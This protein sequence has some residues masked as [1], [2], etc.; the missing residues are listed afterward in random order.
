M[1][2]VSNRIFPTILKETEI[3]FHECALERRCSSIYVIY[4]NI[5]KCIFIYVEV[6]FMCAGMKCLYLWSSFPGIWPIPPCYI[7]HLLDPLERDINIF[8]LPYI[9]IITY[10]ELHYNTSI[11][12]VFLLPYIFIILCKYISPWK[13]HKYI[14]IAIYFNFSV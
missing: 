12:N 4:I 3:E 9:S 5:Y 11:I 8:L 2:I 6:Y 10:I 13:T 7:W 14:F 1:E